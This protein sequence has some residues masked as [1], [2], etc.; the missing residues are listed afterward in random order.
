MYP[1]NVIEKCRSL[2]NAV[3]SEDASASGRA[4]NF[5]CGC[6]AAFSLDVDKAKNVRAVAF[7]SN[8][9][10]YMLAASDILAEAV[11]GT[12]LSDLHGLADVELTVR[13][14]AEIGTIPA[15][16]RQCAAASI[17]AL[18]NAFADLRSRQIEEFRGE[19]ALICTCFSVSEDT[20]TEFIEQNSPAT[21]DDVTDACRAGGGCGS[22][23]MLIEEILD[24]ARSS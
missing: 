11:M 3:R 21:V 2:K 15:R 18:H 22:C 17:G 1:E 6:F 14:E 16:R 20:I 8:G 10:G 23:R 12:D 9:C 13:I 4:V 7:R 24:A 19:T 5:A